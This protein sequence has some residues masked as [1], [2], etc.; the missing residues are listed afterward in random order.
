MPHDILLQ[1]EEDSITLN[2]KS[3]ED[4]NDSIIQRDE[5]GRVIIDIPYLC[6]FCQR[7]MFKWSNKEH[8]D[9]ELVMEEHFI[10]SVCPNCTHWQT[11]WHKDLD[12]DYY[13][14]PFSVWESRISKLMEY[15]SNLPEACDLEITKYIRTRKNFW[16]TISPRK[17]ELLVTDI[18]RLNHADSDVTHVG[19]PDDGGIDAIFI[20]S[21]R[22]KW[23]IQVKRRES[24]SAS[25]GVEV[26]RNLLGSMVLGKTQYGIVVSTADHFTYRAHKAQNDA[27]S[28]GY[29]IKLIDQGI[30]NKMIGPLLDEGHWIESMKGKRSDWLP[31]AKKVIPCR[32]QLYLLDNS[33]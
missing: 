27:K 29:T 32:G 24:P 4:L 20:E 31:I 28:C 17:L 16:N 19:R 13:G 23:F 9:K 21:N 25:E 3:I 30:L 2:G 7:E 15:E 22:R 14:H 11:Y 33:H 10:V 26:I 5:I 18:F 1:D 12:E 8:L 6:P